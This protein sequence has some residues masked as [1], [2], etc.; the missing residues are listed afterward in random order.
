MSAR[1]EQQVGV[2]VDR[3]KKVYQ[4]RGEPIVALEE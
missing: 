3:V 4:T 2:T 1:H